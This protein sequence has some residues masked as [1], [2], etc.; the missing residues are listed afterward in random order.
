MCGELVCAL[1]KSSNLSSRSLSPTTSPHL[2]TSTMSKTA[3]MPSVSVTTQTHTAQ[4]DNGP[5]YAVRV[6][7]KPGIYTSYN[8]ALHAAENYPCSQPKKFDTRAKAEDYMEESFTCAPE[9]WTSV[10]LIDDETDAYTWL[11]YTDGACENNGGHRPKGGI[12][13][14]F[15][16]LHPCNYSGPLVGDVQTNQRAELSAILK[17]LE[18]IDNRG[19]NLNWQIRSDSQ[20]AVNCC[21][22]WLEGWKKNGFKTGKGKEVENQDLILAIDEYLQKPRTRIGTRIT[23][24]HIPGH[25]GENEEVDALAK[26]GIT[27]SVWKP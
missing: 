26:Q 22:Q 13:V 10:L 24:K 8:A 15:G 25:A 7:H 2:T 9:H 21:S 4:A 20:Y 12:G 18:I 3:F 1:K 16:E 27:E 17:A 5:Y 11:A 6:G 14:Y 23:F 19:E